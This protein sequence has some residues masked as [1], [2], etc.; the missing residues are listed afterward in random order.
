MRS[1][2]VTGVSTGIGHSTA[3]QLAASGFHVFGSVRKAADGE[4]LKRALGDRF[5]ALHFDVI[6]EQAVAAAAAQVRE[7]LAGDTLAG[8]VNN[9]GIAVAGPLSHIPLADY[10][11]QLEVNLVG[12]LIVTQA[13]LPQLGM[14]PALRGDK[15]RIVNISSVGGKL[16]F[17]FLGPYCASKFGLEGLSE[18]WRRELM[19]HGI[20]VVVIG[21]GSVVTPIW[22]KAEQLDEAPY[23]QLAIAPA[24]RKFQQMFVS[25]GR[26]GHPPEAVAAAIHHALTTASPKVR[27]AVVR[28]R[29]K[30]WT[31]PSSLPPAVLDGL[32]AGQ[33]GLKP[34][35]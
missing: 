35:A 2:V 4:R 19:M 28:G 29:F 32:V 24:L 5:T 6:D 3:T 26:Q 1:I 11:R 21:P 17:P 22:D 13:F 9:A 10:R 30:N 7:A 16:A 12:P 8:L 31:L 25:E 18:S 34:K 14:D 20:K 27:Y 23:A 15:G 33:L